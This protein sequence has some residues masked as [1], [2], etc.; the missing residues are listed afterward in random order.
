MCSTEGREMQKII[1]KNLKIVSFQAKIRDTPFE[2]KLFAPP[3]V[4]I[5]QWHTHTNTHTDGHG[6]SLTKSARLVDSV[7]ILHT[8]DTESL[9]LCR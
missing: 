2:Q 6:D 3:E 5:L 8:G 7:K 1:I 9:N 4:G